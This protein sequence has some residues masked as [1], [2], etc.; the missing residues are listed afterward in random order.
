MVLRR[1]LMPMG[2]MEAS[3]PFFFSADTGAADINAT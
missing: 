1:I 2:V 3:A